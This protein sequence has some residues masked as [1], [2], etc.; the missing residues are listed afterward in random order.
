MADRLF[1]RRE[2]EKIT[3]LAR[4]TIYRFMEQGSSPRPV[5]IGKVAVRWRQ[6]D[7]TAWVESRPTARGELD[8]RNRK[9][10]R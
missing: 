5:Q 2:V 3:G 9:E 6:S 8:L 1:R 7:V 4:S 10:G